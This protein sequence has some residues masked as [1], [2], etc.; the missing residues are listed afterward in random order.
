[1][2]LIDREHPTSDDKP[3]WAGMV[4]KQ[5]VYSD[6]MLESLK[7]RYPQGANLRER[8]HMAAIEF[9]QQELRDMQASEAALI[10]TTHPTISIP[11]V[12]LHDRKCQRNISP[13]CSPTAIYPLPDVKDKCYHGRNPTN[14]PFLNEPLNIPNSVL[15]REI[16]FSIADEPIVQRQKRK[17]M[18]A[19][20]KISYKRMRRI[21]A[22]D[23]CK[24]QKAK[25]DS[26][27]ILKTR[28][29]YARLIQ[30]SARMSA[31]QRTDPEIPKLRVAHHKGQSPEVLL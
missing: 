1:M 24:R 22:C 30:C 12:A 18:T 27:I 5:R 16:V 21:G 13:P 4:F 11:D 19:T 17:K 2:D 9:L 3:P 14:T 8:K 15:G 7:R 26:S 25:V 10:P 6:D 28:L 23:S 20:E 31:A 29:E